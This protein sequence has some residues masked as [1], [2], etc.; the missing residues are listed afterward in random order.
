M[1]DL[2]VIGLLATM[3]TIIIGGDLATKRRIRKQERNSKDAQ[4]T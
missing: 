3:A 2:F 4:K 1:P